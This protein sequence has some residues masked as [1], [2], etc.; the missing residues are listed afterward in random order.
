MGQKNRCLFFS[1]AVMKEAL[2]KK[3][4]AF[5]LSRAMVISLSVS[6][7]AAD[8]SVPTDCN[9]FLSDAYLI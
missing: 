3:L 2:T 8:T 6:A 7:F 5:I 9:E 4:L 1:P